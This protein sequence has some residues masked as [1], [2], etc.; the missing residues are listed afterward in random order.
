[1]SCNIE[2]T[3]YYDEEKQTFVTEDTGWM[4]YIGSSSAREDLHEVEIKMVTQ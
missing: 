1:M 2:D 4:V 3:A